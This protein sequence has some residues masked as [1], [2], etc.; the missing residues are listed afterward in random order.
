MDREQAMTTVRE[1]LASAVPG[2]DPSGL[3]PDTVIR[4]ELEIDSLDFL[5]FVEILADRTGV[6]IGEEDY[7]RLGTLADCAEFLTSRE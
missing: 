4:D 1:S 2:A 6:P 3:T 5:S 7:S